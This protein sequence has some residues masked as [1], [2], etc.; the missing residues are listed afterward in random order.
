M[1]STYKKVTSKGTLR[2]VFICLRPTFLQRPHGPYPP[3]LHTV[4]EYTVYLFTHG[5]GGGESWTREKVR[6]A[7]VHK[8][9]SKIPTW[10]AVSLVYTFFGPPLF[11][12]NRTFILPSVIERLFTYYGMWGGGGGGCLWNPPKYK[13]HA[14]GSWYLGCFHSSYAAF[15]GFYSK[16]SLKRIKK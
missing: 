10:L 9:G 8:A 5:E 15:C 4:Y 2:Q 3:P 14:C 7:T 13:K 12:L 11:S 1:S 16:S 6:G